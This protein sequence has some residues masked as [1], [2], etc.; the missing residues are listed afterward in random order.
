MKAIKYMD[1]DVLLKKATELLIK[2]L[3]P[4]EAIRFI[5]MQGKKRVD[6]VKRHREWQKYLDK[7]IFY[8]EIFETSV[9]TDFEK[10]LPVDLIVYTKPMYEKFVGLGSMFSKTI[11]K[12]GL[13]LYEKINSWKVYQ[14]YRHDSF[15]SIG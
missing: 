1:E 11:L 10:K 12:K 6:S 3:G 8:D 4:I 13:V 2:E 7:N 14:V 15:K 5:S 9:I